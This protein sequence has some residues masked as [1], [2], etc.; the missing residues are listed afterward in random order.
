[1][2]D[3]LNFKCPYID[4]REIWQ[5]ADTFR[6]KYRPEET[7]PVDIESIVEKRLRLNIEPV[8]YWIN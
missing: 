7:L 5:S 2:Q 3:R 4:K 6:N 8:H 1:M